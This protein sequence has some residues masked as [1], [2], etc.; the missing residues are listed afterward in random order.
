M[1]ALCCFRRSHRQI[2]FDLLNVFVQNYK[3]NYNVFVIKIKILMS[4]VES[5]TQRPV[6]TGIDI[7]KAS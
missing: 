4:C 7:R 2:G 1:L 5:V 6:H 3:S